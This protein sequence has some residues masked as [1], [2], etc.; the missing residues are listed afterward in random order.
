MLIGCDM[1]RF[2]R[3]SGAQCGVLLGRTFAYYDRYRAGLTIAHTSRPF[4]RNQSFIGSG[5]N[6]S[7]SECIDIQQRRRKA[8]YFRGAKIDQKP[9]TLPL[10]ETAEAA[11]ETTSSLN[12]FGAVSSVRR[13]IRACFE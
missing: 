2:P 10:A 3:S 1:S 4:D 7:P 12:D 13:S 11:T 5:T 9:L 8:I 6:S